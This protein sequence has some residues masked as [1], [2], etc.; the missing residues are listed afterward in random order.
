MISWALKRNSDN[1]R[2]ATG[3]GGGGGGTMKSSKEICGQKLNN[4]Q[5]ILRSLISPTLPHQYSL[6]AH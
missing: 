4:R 5:M 6:S 2:D 1:A 3:G